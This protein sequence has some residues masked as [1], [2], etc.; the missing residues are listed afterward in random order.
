MRRLMMRTYECDVYVCHNARVLLCSVIKL[1][2][3]FQAALISDR[4]VSDVWGDLAARVV[5]VLFIRSFMTRERG[6]YIRGISTKRN[7]TGTLNAQHPE[8]L[9]R[10][11][12]CEYNCVA[13]A[14]ARAPAPRNF[15]QK[16]LKDIGRLGGKNNGGGR[17][18]SK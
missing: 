2:S 8:I 1:S 7:R 9:V 11:M 3:N 12:R 14:R 17:I 15:R 10:R 5:V 13:R 16:E 4:R 18:C 6:E